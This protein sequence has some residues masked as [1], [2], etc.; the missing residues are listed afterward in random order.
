M[1]LKIKAK[2]ASVY[3]E[4][5]VLSSKSEVLFCIN[6]EPLS[7]PRL[8]VL[9]DGEHVELARVTNQRLDARERAHIIT[10]A[11]GSVW[12]LTRRFRNKAST[13]ESIITIAETGVQAITRRSWTNRFEL[14]TAEGSVL[15]SGRQIPADRGDAYELDIKDESQLAQLVLLALI[16]RYILRQ[17]APAPTTP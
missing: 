3:S 16:T 13:T 5:E 7:A 10:W 9:K 12:H 14:R 11:D 17:D 4:V 8:S 1:K 15:A 2:L 6:T